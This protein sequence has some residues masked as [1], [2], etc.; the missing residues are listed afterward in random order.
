MGRMA[1]RLDINDILT[2]KVAFSLWFPLARYLF[3]TCKMTGMMYTMNFGNSATCRFGFGLK[4]Q[5][6]HGCRAH[7]GRR[8]RRQNSPRSWK[9]TVFM[10]EVRIQQGLHMLAQ[11]RH[12]LPNNLAAKAR[13]HCAELVSNSLPITFHCQTSSACAQLPELHNSHY[14]RV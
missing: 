12:L 9:I 6:Q 1:L 14:Q 13:N 2:M 4:L 5:L 11:K 10:S 8:K 3:L 7:Q